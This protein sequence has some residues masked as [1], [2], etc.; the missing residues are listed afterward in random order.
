MSLTTICDHFKEDVDRRK[1]LQAFDNLPVL[2]ESKPVTNLTDIIA[3]LVELGPAIRFQLSS[4]TDQTYN[5]SA[6]NH[7]DI[8]YS[9]EKLQYAQAG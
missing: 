6:C 5:A 2:T 1:L 8:C 3:E 7:S 4:T 9:C